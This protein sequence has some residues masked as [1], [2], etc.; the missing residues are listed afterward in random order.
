M[1]T[2]V[3]MAMTETMLTLWRSYVYPD[4]VNLTTLNQY[5]NLS[6]KQRWFWVDHK[7]I[8]YVFYVSK[9]WSEEASI[10]SKLQ[11]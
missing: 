1:N 11:V 8:F 2:E 5:W 4:N 7:T 6:L 10:S 3:K 9:K